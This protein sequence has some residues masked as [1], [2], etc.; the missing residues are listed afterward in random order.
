MGSSELL[1]CVREKL[2]CS[3]TRKTKI[4]KIKNIHIKYILCQHH[5]F[6]CGLPPLARRR[7]LAARHLGRARG[8]HAARHA[9]AGPRPAGLAPH[10]RRCAGT[11][12]R[13]ADAGR[14]RRIIRADAGHAGPGPRDSGVDR[15]GECLP[16]S[17][18]AARCQRGVDVGQHAARVVVDAGRRRF[19]ARRRDHSRDRGS[20]RPASR[21]RARRR[22]RTRGTWRWRRARRTGPRRP[23]AVR[24]SRGLQG[25]QQEVDASPCLRELPLGEARAQQRVAAGEAVVDAAPEPPTALAD[26]EPY[27]APGAIGAMAQAGARRR[28]MEC[29]PRGR[30]PPGWRSRRCASV[31]AAARRSRSAAW[32]PGPRQRRRSL[33]ANGG[34]AASWHVRHVGTDDQAGALGVARHLD[35]HRDEAALLRRTLAGVVDE[36]AGAHVGGQHLAAGGAGAGAGVGRVEAVAVRL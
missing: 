34:G 25:V 20:A 30:P 3:S 14:S 16:F 31:P 13:P 27:D 12:R 5:Y 15:R 17:P 19:R 11:V 18:H 1:R 7:P 10:G 21:A 4:G 28:V 29:S 9:A 26:G 2:M 36:A 35:L 22:R 33:V 32:R 6:C 23:S 8:R 24:R